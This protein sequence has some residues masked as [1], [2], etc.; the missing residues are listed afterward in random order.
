MTS[1]YHLGLGQIEFAQD[2]FPMAYFWTTLLVPVYA[3]DVKYSRLYFD[4]HS[5]PEQH[6]LSAWPPLRTQDSPSDHCMPSDLS[7]RYLGPIV[8]TLGPQMPIMVNETI[9]SVNS[10]FRSAQESDGTT[11]FKLLF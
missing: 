9:D 3:W 4:W 1:S 8:T 5:L 6:P 10:F 11:H 7:L 2:Y